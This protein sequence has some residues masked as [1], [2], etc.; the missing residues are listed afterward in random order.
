MLDTKGADELDAD[1]AEAVAFGNAASANAQIQ[2]YRQNHI[3][4]V[5]REECVYSVGGAR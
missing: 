2:K 1:N 4:E 5:S 3:L